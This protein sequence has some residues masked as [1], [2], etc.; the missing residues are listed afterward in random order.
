MVTPC[1]FNTVLWRIV[2]LRLNGFEEGYY[3]LL[4]QNRN[5]DFKIFKNDANLEKS[6]MSNNYVQRMN[7]FAKGFLKLREENDK[8]FLSDLR[9]EHEPHYFFT[10][11]LA[12]RDLSIL[13][14][15]AMRKP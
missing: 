4:D 12:E 14:A 10:A 6:L 9:V 2:V 5:I 1:P 7:V 8:A 13:T 15:G 3:S 11:A